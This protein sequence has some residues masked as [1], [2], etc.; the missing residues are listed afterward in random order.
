MWNCPGTGC[1]PATGWAACK[2]A[3]M[4]ELIHLVKQFGELT[5]VNDL[6][7][8]V[9]RGEFFAVLGPN[10]AGKTTTIKIWRD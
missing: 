10:A 4:I 9:A 1:W 2:R 8:S 3:T 6:S 5:A 7:L